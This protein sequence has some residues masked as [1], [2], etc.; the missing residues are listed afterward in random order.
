MTDR[1]IVGFDWT[2]K[3][4]PLSYTIGG[5]TYPYS[6]QQD[7]VSRASDANY[8]AYTTPANTLL[9]FTASLTTP[10][11]TIITEY[12]WDFG[13]GA[14][15]YGATVS[16]TYSVGSYQ[17]QVTLNVTDSFGKRVFANRVINLRPANGIQ[18]GLG[19]RVA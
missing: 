9:T 5:T 8:L 4:V 14:I 13:D 11:G 16:H 10:N 15:G 7:G 18:V 17:T 19:A 2:P 6:T 3:S 1:V 12:K